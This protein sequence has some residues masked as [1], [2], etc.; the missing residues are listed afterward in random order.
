[1]KKL[2]LPLL[3]IL[4]FTSCQKQ[5]ST[6]KIP[7]IN[8]REK[9]STGTNTPD[10]QIDICHREGNGTWHTIT[11]SIDAL[12]AH[13]AHGD[14]VPDEDGDGYSKTTPCGTGDDCDD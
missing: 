5:I 7:E 12:P 6:E 14:M 2:L 4:L 3:A 10:A 1:M 8:A 11:I 13:L 9:V